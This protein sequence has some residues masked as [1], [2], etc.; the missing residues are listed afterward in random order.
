MA[1]GPHRTLQSTRDKLAALRVYLS[2]PESERRFTTVATILGIPNSTAEWRVK[3]AMEMFAESTNE[4]RRDVAMDHL[5]IM[6]A[7]RDEALSV[8][9][10]L[11]ERVAAANAHK[12]QAERY[13]K[14]FGLDLPVKAEVEHSGI[15]N[16]VLDPRVLGIQT[17][18]A[19]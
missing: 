17:D 14:L 8:E 9:R 12:A 13:A 2:L 3:A 6:D 19:E 15:Q 16:I 5:Q 7:M 4:M 10:E 11:G 1:Q 18:Q